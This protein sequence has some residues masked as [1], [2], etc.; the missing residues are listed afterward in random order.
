MKTTAQKV[1]RKAKLLRLKHKAA[2]LRQQA[3]DL[4]SS[5]DY[6][7]ATFAKVLADVCEKEARR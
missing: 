6:G 7:A 1:R 2:L 5:G 3:K 4:R